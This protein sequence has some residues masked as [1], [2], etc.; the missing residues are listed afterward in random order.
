MSVWERVTFNCR[1]LRGGCG[2]C[3]AAQHSGTAG[4]VMSAK[5]V[6]ERPQKVSLPV[7]FDCVDERARRHILVVIRVRTVKEVKIV[8]VDDRRPGPAPDPQR[9]VHAALF[10]QRHFIG[11]KV[12][13]AGLPS[14]HSVFI[15]GDRCV[16]LVLELVEDREEEGHPRAVELIQVAVIVQIELAWISDLER[17]RLRGVFKRFVLVSCVNG[18]SVRRGLC[19]REPGQCAVIHA[20]PPE[21][22]CWDRPRECPG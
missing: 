15:G 4:P 2:A 16:M 19:V 13:G 10:K 14:R 9:I 22:A 1:G 6:F 18:A 7:G 11:Q 8:Q 5:T 17:R 20:S 3:A 12:R 21:A